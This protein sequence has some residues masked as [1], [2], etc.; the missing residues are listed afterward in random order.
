M[1]GSVNFRNRGTGFSYLS[2]DEGIRVIIL[3][4]KVLILTNNPN[5][6]STARVLPVWVDGLQ[7]AGCRVLTAG[8][9]GSLADAFTVGGRAFH[10]MNTPRFSKNNLPILLWHAFLIRSRFG[11][12][13]LVHCNEHNVWPIGSIIAKVHTAATVCHARFTIPKEFGQWAFKRFGR[14]GSLLWTS[15]FQKQDAQPWITDIVPESDQYMVKLGLNV[16]GFGM[17]SNKGRP[18]RKTFGIPDDAILVGSASPFRPIKHI[19]ETFEIV[20]RLRTFFPNVF[21]VC[22]GGSIPG[23]EQY[24]QQM[25]NLIKTSGASD[26]FFTPGHIDDVEPFYHA[27]DMYVSTSYVETFGNSVVEAMLCG[28]PVLAYEGGS[29]KEVVGD[30]GFICQNGQL[31]EIVEKAKSWIINRSEMSAVGGSARKRAMDNYNAKDRVGDLLE[32][33]KKVLSDRNGG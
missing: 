13:D 26:W 33:Y 32:I 22:I 17:N 1:E 15:E 29:V 27:M 12:V 7:E 16:Q 28:K 23:E 8:P 24:F 31:H 3:K 21:G 14:P 11:R 19:E 30:V 5:Q 2:T 10:R 18:I 4:M 20:K 6:G 9:S 25:Q